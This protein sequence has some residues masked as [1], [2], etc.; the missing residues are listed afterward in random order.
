MHSS[1]LKA[2]GL[3]GWKAVIRDRAL[4]QEEVLRH[5]SRALARGLLDQN[6]CKW[7]YIKIFI[8][9]PHWSSFY[10]QYTPCNRGHQR[11]DWL[12]GELEELFLGCRRGTWG[13]PSSLAPRYEYSL[14]W[15]WW[16]A[17]SWSP[18][19]SPMCCWWDISIIRSLLP[20]FID[21][22]CLIHTFPS[23]IWRWSFLQ[24]SPKATA[25]F[26]PRDNHVNCYR[27]FE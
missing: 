22:I 3:H 11:P 6:Q 10:R 21:N 19:P 14:V 17:S 12:P 25:R 8:Y 27:V 2:D 4:D 18:H 13:A 5:W 15:M 23:S 7:G 20:A 9:E 1:N 26:K 24:T 16:R